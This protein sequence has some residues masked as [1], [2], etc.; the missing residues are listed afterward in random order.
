M[1]PFEFGEY[2]LTT[3][4]HPS[5]PSN[6]DKVEV[7]VIATP[8]GTPDNEITPGTTYCPGL[9][10]ARKVAISREILA[11]SGTNKQLKYPSRVPRHAIKPHP[12]SDSIAGGTT[13]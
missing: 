2:S 4:I 8:I 6:K 11:G 9:H 3:L 12:T 1:T 5:R 10:R 7:N 13:K